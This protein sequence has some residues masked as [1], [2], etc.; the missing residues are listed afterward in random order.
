VPDLTDLGTVSADGLTWTFTLR[1]GI[2]Y[3]DGTPVVVR[4]LAY[5]IKRSFAHDVFT[6][7]PRYQDKY[8]KGGDRYKGPYLSGDDYEGVR[9]RGDRT[10]IIRLAQ[11]FADLPF[12]LTFPAFTP[13][14][15][16]RDTRL[17]YRNHPVATGPYMVDSY[18]AGSEL[19]LKRNP[20][21]DP[22][23]DT[24]RHQYPDAWDFR[25]GAD[26]VRTQQRVLASDGPD[27][28]AISYDNVDATLIP[29]LT[30]DKKA[31]LVQGDSP[32]TSVFQL[33]TRK[34]PL[35]V[36]RAVAVAWPY[37]QTW[38]AMGLNRYTA[39]PASTILPPAVP[40]H[41]RYPPVAGLSGTGPG[42][43]AAARR[44]LTAAGRL[45]FKL[46]WYYDN[47]QPVAQQTD[48]IRTRALAAAGFTVEAI[49][50][51]TADLRA[52]EA[53]Y[54]AP[55]NA[56][57]TPGGWCSAWPSGSSWFPVLF[58][59]HS[60]ADGTS[61]GM[62]SDPAL[63]TEIEAVA[64]L[65]AGPAT[66]RWA[67]LDREILSTYVVLPLFYDKMAVVEGTAIGGAEGDATVGL[68]FLPG[69]FVKD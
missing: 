49:G 15:P 3:E 9:T 52:K 62:L 46:S 36:R 67:A 30:G 25:W 26:H 34:I 66:G 14:P 65:P 63:D 19:K 11:P 58:E 1:P 22:A 48:Q 6:N 7:G 60:I 40:G 2:R 12:Y 8:F 23:T 54:G 32:C 45:G 13:I 56:G 35:A 31:Q 61:W 17:D 38:K 18:L 16:A 27:A 59:S 20:H 21:W 47:T 51:A 68:P 53:D 39:E 24:V 28:A 4:D 64:G 42:D 41:T 44:M 29:Q 69:L 57:Q 5:A 10:L 37:D 33:D 55:V 50:V 43:P